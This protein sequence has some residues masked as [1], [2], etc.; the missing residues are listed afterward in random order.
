MFIVQVCARNIR[1]NAGK[2]VLNL[3]VCLIT[4]L[5]LAFYV[6]NIFVYQKQ[7]DELPNKLPVRAEIQ[8]VGGT[9]RTNLLIEES[10]VGV[11]KELPYL[12]DLHLTVRLLGKF[13]NGREFQAKGVDSL[14][15]FEGMDAQKVSL[16]PER[17]GK[18]LQ[19]AGAE[20]LPSQK[21]LGL[22]SDT[23]MPNID[24][25][26][27]VTPS[28]LKENQLKAGDVFKVRLSSYIVSKK[29]II[30]DTMILRDVSLRVIGTIPE[31]E[32]LAD[33][34]WPEVI[35]PVNWVEKLCMQSRL[36]LNFDSVSFYIRDP[37]KLNDFKEV[38]KENNMVPV[39]ATSSLSFKGVALSVDDAVFISTAESIQK[40]L[41]MQRGFLPFMWMLALLIAY[42]VPSLLIQN[43]KKEVAML[44]TLGNGQW[45]CVFAFSL[46]YGSTAFLGCAASAGIA[47]S[48]GHVPTEICVGT[49]FAFWIMYLLGSIVTLIG[50][51]RVP[52][53]AALTNKE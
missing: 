16:S 30:P 2:S 31:Q 5:L 27:L 14:A 17:T 38:M 43:R 1:R 33:E 7:M 18:L 11:L 53:M 44:R 23:L 21:I 42:I 6:G 37:W 9:M 10:I 3:A 32:K 20:A 47:V 4:A 12:S 49:V 51:G 22:D 39:S 26:C 24:T 13:P 48:V 45:W 25:E 41:L 29:T 19:G 36:P 35:V 40:A 52:V 28:F 50:I 8:N 15:C 46:E 34:E